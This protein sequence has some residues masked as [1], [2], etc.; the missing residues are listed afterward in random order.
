MSLDAAD[1]KRTIAAHEAKARDLQTKVNALLAIEKVSVSLLYRK[2][3]QPDRQDVRGCVEQLNTIEKEVRL[4][5]D[6]Q[7]SLNDVKDQLDGRSIEKSELKSKREVGRWR[8]K[9]EFTLL[10]CVPI[11]AES[12]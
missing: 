6:T 10:R 4:L 9:I 8:Q 12:R 11:Y 7:K 5:Q 1:D 3:R 2:D